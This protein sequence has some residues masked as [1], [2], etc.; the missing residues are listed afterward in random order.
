M[1]LFTPSLGG[2]DDEK[3]S[4]LAMSILSICV[5]TPV[6]TTNV[7]GNVEYLE[8][9]GLMSLLVDVR[10]YDFPLELTEKLIEVLTKKVHVDVSFVLSWND[11]A[12]RFHR[13][14]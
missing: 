3:C 8:T 5:R 9:V 14:N 6:A 4:Y 11:I 1:K 13:N 12:L 2:S 10:R 7:G